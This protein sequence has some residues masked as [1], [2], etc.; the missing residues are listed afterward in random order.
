LIVPA[1][2]DVTVLPQNQTIPQ[3]PQTAHEPEVAANFTANPNTL[4]KIVSVL[5]KSKAFTVDQTTNKISLKPFTG[6]ASQ[7]FVV[8][9]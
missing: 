8:Y 3:E 2:Q 9:T 5:D 4:Y 7:K 6:D 1:N